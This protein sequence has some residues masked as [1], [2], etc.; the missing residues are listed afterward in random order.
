VTSS[1]QINVLGRFEARSTSGEVVD[2]NSKKAVALLGY[3]A[4]E[5]RHAHAREELA[6][7][8]WSRMGDERARHNLRQALVK[9][10]ACS[11]SLLIASGES[12]AIDQQSC[13]V[14]VIE[15]ERLSRAEEPEALGRCLELYAGDLL[16]G[17]TLRE[18]AFEEWL[19]PTRARLRQTACNTA[20]KLVELLIAA[21]R[22]EEAVKTLHHR[23]VMDPACEPA[24]ADLM[25]LFVRLGRRSDALRQYQT[26]VESLR[27]ELAAEPSAETRSLYASIQRTEAGSEVTHDAH[28]A[29]VAAPVT[30]ERPTIA[31]LPF[32]NLSGDQ[33]AYFVDGIVEDLITALS[34]FSTRPFRTAR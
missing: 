25:K 1:L 15:F 33:D 27:R 30:H 29:A 11:D 6:N 28:G 14:D 13:S 26:C 19:I 21:D 18:A 20:D 5:A 10:R 8:L 17:L 23:L 2:F 7:L 22:T 3:L 31:V 34:R 12:L 9:I 24:H 32:D 4:V 16:E